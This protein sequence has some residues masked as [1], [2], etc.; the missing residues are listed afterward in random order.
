MGADLKKCSGCSCTKDDF[1]TARFESEQLYNQTPI[2]D[3]NELPVKSMS[4]VN[5]KD[6][7]NFVKNKSPSPETIENGCKPPLDFFS[8]FR[9]TISPPTIVT[10][11][12]EKTKENY[13]PKI[14]KIQKYY[15]G[16]AYRHH[17]PA[18]KE[19]QIEE[20]NQLLKDLTEQYT[21]LN[22]KRAESLI[23]SKYDKNGW[24]KLYLN[25]SDHLFD[26]NDGFTMY[27]KILIVEGVFTAFYSGDVNIKYERNGYGVLLQSDG[28]KLEGH[29]INNKFTGWGRRIDSEGTFYEGYFKDSQLCGKGI[30]R[31]SKGNSY[32]GDFVDNKREGEGKEETNEHIYEGEFAN[33]KKNGN[34][35]LI[36]K[37]LKDTY[38]GEFQ[39]NFITGV[40]FYTWANHDTFKGS[41]VNGKMHG[42][43]LYK[44][45]DGGEYYGDYVNNIKEGIGIFKWANGKIFEGQ[46]KNGRPSGLGK[47][48]TGTKEVEVE[49]RDGK[50]LSKQRY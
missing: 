45:P 3:K 24:K 13:I 2:D 19:K 9:Q 34:G 8:S 7:K 30:K 41:F 6:L 21:K 18:L 36:Y 48:R 49:F 50:L 14:I 44:W 23:G 17:Y 22:L 46:F 38:E 39:D 1:T 5:I 28:C 25:D 32:I 26:T 43:G 35:I 33:D 11:K 37:L 27:T 15:R 4:L 12:Q 31:S 16:I 42:K 29:W 20:T 10:I 47:L 40:G